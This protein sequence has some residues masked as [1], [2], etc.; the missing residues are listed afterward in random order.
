MVSFYSHH[1]AVPAKG[2]SMIPLYRAVTR[3]AKRIRGLATLMRQLT[4]ILTALTV[5]TFQT[6]AGSLDWLFDVAN[7]DNIARRQ[8]QFLVWDGVPHPFSAS[9]E[10]VDIVDKDW[11]FYL[12]HVVI[13]SPGAGVERDR[14]SYL[15]CFKL[16]ERTTEFRI[17][18][19]IQ[20]ASDP[21]TENEITIDKRLNGWPVSPPWKAGDDL[22]HN[23]K[24][25][26]LSI[27]LD[28]CRAGSD[29]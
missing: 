8:A 5:V 2:I 11:P 22:P 13:T 17:V 9:F 12:F 29:Q 25:P 24:P 1:V 21:P 26:G 18:T 7:N 20:Y 14:S 10:K 15:V 16:T 28:K 19:V 27:V 6:H 4:V 23:I 3:E